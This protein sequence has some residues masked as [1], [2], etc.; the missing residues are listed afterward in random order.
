[1]TVWVVSCY[2]EGCEEC[3]NEYHIVG[4]FSTKALADEAYAKHSTYEHLHHHHIEIDELVL[5]KYVKSFTEK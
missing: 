1:M 4:V 5:D 2:M 3:G